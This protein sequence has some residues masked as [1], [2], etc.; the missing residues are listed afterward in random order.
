MRSFT[1]SSEA[2]FVLA[3]ALT[4]GVLVMSWELVL[5]RHGSATVDVFQVTSRDTAAAHGQQWV[6]FGNCLM[7]TGVSP[8]RLS[9]QL[10]SDPERRIVNIAAHE[11]SPL[12]FFAYLRSAHR[13]PDVVI[14]NVSSWLNGTNFEQEGELVAKQDPLTL[15]ALVPS[16]AGAKASDGQQAYKQDGD[17]GAGGLQ[18]AVEA[19]LTG[20]SNSHVQA[21]GHRYHLFDYGLFLGTLATTANMDTSLYQ[22]GMQSWFKVTGSDTDGRGYLGLHVQYRADW[23]QGLERMAERSLQRLRL[24]RLLTPRY[25][26]LLEGDVRDFQSHGTQ[27]FLVRMPEHPRIKAFNDETYAVPE[28]LHAI[29]TR[30]GAPVLDLS[31]LG[32]ADGVR[33]FDA[34]H[35]DAAA[36]EV[37]DR[38]VGVWLR[39]HVASAG[40]GLP[41]RAGGG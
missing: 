6:I 38:E 32:P 13:Y 20:W 15:G 18:R 22:L 10:A 25:W 33:L 2:R 9:E 30:T 26:E 16:A 35:P 23:D 4:F 41:T 29:E 31:H 17:L 40:S 12:A 8:R 24:S 27:V 21:F 14:A 37:I 19:A 28:R 11:Q 34:V 5:R 1:S 3:L 7:M 36:A 39:S